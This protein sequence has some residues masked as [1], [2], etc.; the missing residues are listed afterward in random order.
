MKMRYCFSLHIRLVVGWL[1]VLLLVAAEGRAQMHQYNT[2]FDFSLRHFTDTIPIEVEDD[3]VL[4]RVEMGG[5]SYR[6]CLDTGSGQGVVY[7]GSMP[8]GAVGLGHV[9]SRDAAGLRDTVRV[10]QLPRLRMGRLE[11]DGYV[12]TVMP[13]RRGRLQYDG[14][15]G[16]DLINKGLCVK[17]DTKRGYMVVSDRR[18]LFDQE[19]G[20]GLRYKLKW[21]VP[22]VLVS[23]FKRHTDEVLFDTGSRQLYT[24]NKESFDKHAYKSKQVE[25]QVLQRVKGALAIGHHGAEKADEVAFMRLDRLLWDELRFLHVGTM[26]TQGASRIGAS[27]LRY[28]T[29]TINGFRRKIAFAPYVQTDSI[30][31]G[32]ELPHIAYVPRKGRATVGLIVE[33]CDEHR[34]GLRQGDTILRVDGREVSS[35]EAFLRWPFIEGRTHKMVVRTL[36]GREKMVEYRVKSEE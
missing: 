9:V 11:V 18:D 33:D 24:M 22:Y 26:T 36:E 15:L 10:V 20:Y 14:I 17:I 12:A 16:F 21:W 8:P 34:A 35:F 5:S 32:N 1:V 7:A 27:L 13:K 29:V 19:P 4:V 25:A 31:V 2:S 30:E 28:G 3:Q 23:P 6:F